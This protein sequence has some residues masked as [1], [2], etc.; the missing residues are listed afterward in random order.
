ML[1]LQYDI[2]KEDYV[3]FYTY[4]FWEQGKKRRRLNFLK[5]AGFLILFLVVLYF[6]GGRGSFNYISII[7]YGM[8]FFSVVLPLL[9][10]KNSIVK[11]AEKITDDEENAS[12]F[13]T[14]RL[15][16]TDASLLIIT[17]FVE[18]KLFWSA[19]IKKSET[20]THYFLFENAMQAII[21]PK[22]ACRNEEERVA[23]SKLLSRN[24]SMDAEFN[25]L[26][27]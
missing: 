4:V 12:I 3:S 11:N 24:L 9:N 6:A 13:S 27:T 19:I 25:Q 14:Y 20:D 22:R 18:T 8:I 16:A 2:T 7:I 5:Q 21:I 1:A 15:V 10:G 17:N 23:L 26:L